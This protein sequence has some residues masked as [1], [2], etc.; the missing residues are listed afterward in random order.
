MQALYKLK[1]R[2]PNVPTALLQRELATVL[3]DTLCEITT[4]G[5]PFI[6]LSAF[7]TQKG[8]GLEKTA[9]LLGFTA[10][11]TIVFGDNQNDLPMFRWAGT[12]VAM[13]NAVDENKS[14]ADAITL[15]NAEHGVAHYLENLLDSGKL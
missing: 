9:T 14:Q 1:V 12:A 4:S 7:G 3:G 2:R 15:S 8:S 6:E 10:A 5:A 13:G 11:D